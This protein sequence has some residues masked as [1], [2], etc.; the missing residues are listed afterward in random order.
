MQNKDILFKV[1][2]FIERDELDFL[3]QI[4]K[5]IY[6]TNGK[7]IPRTELIKEIIHLTKNS[8]E[9]KNLIEKELLSAKKEV[10][11]A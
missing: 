8:Q 10:S 2:A 6:F 9:L 3:D 1:V 7:K 11:H 5:D 4:S